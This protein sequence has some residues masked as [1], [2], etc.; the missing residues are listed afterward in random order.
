MAVVRKTKTTPTKT[1]STK[2]TTAT[3]TTRPAAKS[4]KTAPATRKVTPTTTPK[5]PTAKKPVTTT[6]RTRTAVKPTNPRTAKA[7]AARAAKGATATKTTRATATK[8]VKEVAKPKTKATP[9]SAPRTGPNREVDETTGFAIGTDSHLIAMELLKGGDSRAEII[10]RCAKK[11]PPT[12]NRG[13]PKPVANMVAS[14]L[15]KMR[16]AGFTISSSFVLEPPTRASKAKA[17]RMK[18][19]R[20]AKAQG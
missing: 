7:A 19:A 13:T 4:T 8:T 15:G 6:T 5:K 9:K 1:P 17:T 10:E 16:D 3:K 18:N 12:S 11:L 14:V 20:L 2:S